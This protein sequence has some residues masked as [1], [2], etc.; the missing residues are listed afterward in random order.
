MPHLPKPFFRKP[1]NL[2]YVQLNGTQH[3]LGPDRDAAF[4]AY[5]NLMRKPQKKRYIRSESVVAIIDSFLGYTQKHR[6]PDTCNVVSI[7]SPIVSGSVSR[8]GSART[9]AVPRSRMDRQLSKSVGR[10]QTEPLPLDHAG[11]EMGG[12]N[13]PHRQVPDQP[14]SRSLLAERGRESFP[15]PSGRTFS[16]WFPILTSAISSR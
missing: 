8:S 15:T 9:E 2:W 12:E 4:A 13:R 6:A 1:R 14:I 11:D 3:N 5:H 16:R 7:V 10:L